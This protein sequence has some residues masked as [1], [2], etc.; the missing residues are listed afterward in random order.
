MAA[1]RGLQGFGCFVRAKVGC[2][3]RRFSLIECNDR[4]LVRFLRR[5]DLPRQRVKLRLGGR[6]RDDIGVLG[7][8]RGFTVLLLR[9]AALK[10]AD[11][12]LRRV[13]V[14][15]LRRDVFG[16][17]SEV[18]FESP[19]GMAALITKNSSSSSRAV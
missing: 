1:L 6:T 17:S 4:G 3:T 13:A 5:R 18:R 15:V 7:F 10:V 19:D 8:E 2:G 14:R 12:A 11:L 16:E 9:Q